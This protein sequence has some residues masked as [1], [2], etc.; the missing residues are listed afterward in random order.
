MNGPKICSNN[1]ATT[2]STEEAGAAT[3]TDASLGDG[4]T[5]GA[6]PPEGDG[7]APTDAGSNPG[8]PDTGESMEAETP[9]PEAEPSADAP[10]EAAGSSPDA[11]TTD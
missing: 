9:T 7:T 10:P 8:K 3:P 5:D 1:L 11:D 2:V 6:P 4:P